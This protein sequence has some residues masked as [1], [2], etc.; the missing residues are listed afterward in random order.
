MPLILQPKFSDKTR[1]EIEQH[2]SVVRA[3]RMQAV[4]VFYAGKNAKVMHA[5]AKFMDRINREYTM[6]AKDLARYDKLDEAVE[7]RLA[8]LEQ[9]SHELQSAQDQYVELPDG[10]DD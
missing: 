1:D 2:L 4:A 3:R 7:K 8:T 6:L 5:T 9:L 10:D